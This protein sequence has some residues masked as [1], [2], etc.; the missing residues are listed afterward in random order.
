MQY[1]QVICMCVL[2]TYSS[3]AVENLPLPR[4]LSSKAVYYVKTKQL[5]EFSCGYNALFNAANFEFHC[6]FTNQV[7]RYEA[8]S[9]KI[10]PYLRSQGLDPKKAS[11]SYDIEHLAGEV[12]HLM[13]SFHLQK[14]KNMIE[15]LLSGKTTV[16]FT[17]GTSRA[18]IDRL[19]QSA[20]AKKRKQ[21]IDFLKSYLEME[22]EAVI[23]FICYVK[24]LK[25][26]DHIVLLSLHQNV[27]GRGLYLF[28]NINEQVTEVSD[29]RA[30]IE[31]L[32]VTFSISSS[33]HYRV[34]T[35]P[36]RWT[37]LDTP[38]YSDRTDSSVSK[39]HRSLR[40]ATN[41]R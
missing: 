21:Y 41:M 2:A 12:L 24:T 30:F 11:Y 13:P 8:F 5:N 19:L 40:F 38:D 3:R 25:G 17:E 7:Y 29:I 37:F 27:S 14:N 1:V 10:V 28:D 6:G 32:C 15:L 22:R 4:S 16:S 31:Y 33:S 39:S 23:H 26:D 9:Q 20:L 34:P 35:L 18:E 36:T